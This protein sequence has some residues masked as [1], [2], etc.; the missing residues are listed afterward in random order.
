MSTTKTYTK[1]DCI[2]A[3][4]EV[5]KQIEGDVSRD[6][7]RMLRTLDQ[8]SVRQIRNTFGTWGKGKNAAGFNVR[9][10][11]WER[12]SEEEM[13]DALQTVDKRQGEPL[14]AMDYRELKDSEHP[15]QGTIAR[16]Y[17]GWNNA[18]QEAGIELVKEREAGQKARK[19]LVKN[20]KQESECVVCSEEAPCCLDFHH[21]PDVEKRGSVGQMIYKSGPIKKLRKEIE[22]CVII[23]S[24]CHR[25][26]HADELETDVLQTDVMPKGVNKEM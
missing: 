22:K 12:V 6:D 8:P 17:E 9:G 15:S 26:L 23:C 1:Q 25:K 4:L 5:D 14:S 3:I 18:K 20:V 21:P 2:D 19:E 10:G 24:N 13:I 16:R 7:Y 11:H